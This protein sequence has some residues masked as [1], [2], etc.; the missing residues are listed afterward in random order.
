MTRI[1]IKVQSKCV[2]Y[3]GFSHKTV[4]RGLIIMEK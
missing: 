4:K 3:S 1:Q 2:V